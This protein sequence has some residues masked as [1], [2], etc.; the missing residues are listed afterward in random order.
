MRSIDTSTLE[1]LTQIIN[2]NIERKYKV[3][4]EQ[5]EDILLATCKDKMSLLEDTLSLLIMVIEKYNEQF[6]L[7]EKANGDL[8][9]LKAENNLLKASKTVTREDLR[10]ARVEAGE[11]GN[12][13]RNHG[14]TKELVHYYSTVKKMSYR[15]IADEFGVSTATICRRAREYYRSKGG[16]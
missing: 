11:L 14:V 15:E 1:Y 12:T 2:S 7:I 9:V 4:S 8:K 13:T 16:H 5:V 3:T 6:T 10:K